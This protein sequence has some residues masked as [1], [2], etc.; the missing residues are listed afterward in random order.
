VGPRSLEYYKVDSEGKGYFLTG[1]ITLHCFLSG[2]G[3]S[4][5]ILDYSM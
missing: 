4:R 1:G 2:G 5:S 3:F